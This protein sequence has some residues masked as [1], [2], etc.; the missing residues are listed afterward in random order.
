[1]KEILAQKGQDITLEGLLQ[2]TLSLTGEGISPDSLRQTLKGRGRLEVTNAQVRGVNVL[3]LALS[4]ITVLP[5]LLDAVMNA[6]PENYRDTLTR[7][8]TVI[9]R[10]SFDASIGSGVMHLEPLAVEADG[11][12]FSGNG[13]AAMNGTYSLNGTLAIPKDISRKMI[14]GAKELEFLTDENGMVSFPFS[15]RGQDGSVSFTPDMEYIA[16]RLIRSQGVDK[17]LDKVLGVDEGAQGESPDGAGDGTKGEV[18]TER[19]IL[20]GVLDRILQ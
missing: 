12:M 2:G 11:F 6:V 13:L 7:D 14:S 8:S 16:S 5:N 20:E 3:H 18:S 4:K 1:M 17:L 10:A 15:A 19:R 9:E